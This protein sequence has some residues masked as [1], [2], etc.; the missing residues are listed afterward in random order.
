MSHS[1]KDSSV[2]L[3]PVCSLLN[4]EL[5][6]EVCCL[7]MSYCDHQS[8]ICHCSGRVSFINRVIFDMDSPRN[9]P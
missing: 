9:T 8:R 2:G 5:T 1:W 6:H 4:T 3:L 7:I